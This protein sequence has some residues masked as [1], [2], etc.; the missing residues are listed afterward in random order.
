MYFIYCIRLLHVS[1]SP[2]L[3][4]EA[5]F[6]AEL[7]SERYEGRDHRFPSEQ[8]CRFFFCLFVFLVLA[9]LYAIYVDIR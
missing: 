4:L 2:F 5:F 1:T 6:L 7:V 8:L 9:L 3:R